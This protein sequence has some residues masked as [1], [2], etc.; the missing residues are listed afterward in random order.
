MSNI[1]WATVA[2]PLKVCG[3]VKSEFSN[4]LKSKY[5]LTDKNFGS[6]SSNNTTAVFPYIYI[7]LL[8]ASETE[9]DTEGDNINAGTFTFQVDVT[10]DDSQNS[11][12]I[13]CTEAMRIF[14]SMGFIVNQMPEFSVINNTFKSTIR[15]RRNIGSGEKI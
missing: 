2:V 8:P 10:T 6:V 1:D 7:H 4:E 11:A 14:K 13:L 9:A 5:N 15:C 3:K 12:R